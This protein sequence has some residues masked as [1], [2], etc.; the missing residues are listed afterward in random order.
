MNQNL[1]VNIIITILLFIPIFYYNSLD[2]LNISNIS[3]NYKL[4]DEL[5]IC[6]DIEKCLSNNI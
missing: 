2:L 6:N 1:I 3:Y 4:K 5:D